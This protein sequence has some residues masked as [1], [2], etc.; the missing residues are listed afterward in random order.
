MLDAAEMV[1]VDDIPGC[2]PMDIK[3]EV[4]QTATM[5]ASREERSQSTKMKLTLGHFSNNEPWTSGSKPGSDCHMTS[6]E[7]DGAM[8][9]DS[10]IAGG[11]ERI[12]DDGGR[13]GGN[14][15]PENAGCIQH[16]NGRDDTNGD[17][18]RNSCDK[19]K[20]GGN[21]LSEQLEAFDIM[22]D[23]AEEN[24]QQCF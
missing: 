5:A 10:Q 9:T 18:R 15:N 12:K 16:G 17:Q 20:K 11:K 7:S 3:D 19:E 4:S 23:T 21:H 14:S 24:I 8:A 1:H 6:I 22:S 2:N 13:K